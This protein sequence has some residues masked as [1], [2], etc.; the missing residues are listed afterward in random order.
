VVQ[1]GFFSQHVD[2]RR[3]AS[4]NEQSF[5]PINIY[6]NSVPKE[7]CGATRFLSLE[8]QST[9]DEKVCEIGHVQPVQGLGVIFP[10]DLLHDGE[11]L[12]GGEKYLLRTDLMFT[13]DVP[14]EMD[15]AFLGLSDT[16]KG[17]K[18]LDI[19]SRLEDANN[20]TEAIVWYKRAFRLC[21]DLG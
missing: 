19:A 18:A 5:M 11:T 10:H 20:Q 12:L 14:F 4:L 17:R 9:G 16:E 15:V 3:L 7:H 2:G 21:P 13:R 6:L 1:G 8:K